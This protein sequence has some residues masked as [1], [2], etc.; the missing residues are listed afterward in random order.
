ML[1]RDESCYRWAP[2]QA[3]GDAM[4]VVLQLQVACLIKLPFLGCCKQMQ[5]Y[6]FCHDLKNLIFLG[7]KFYRGNVIKSIIRANREHGYTALIV[8]SLPIVGCSASEDDERLSSRNLIIRALC[9]GLKF[10]CVHEM[11]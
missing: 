4:L 1:V 2:Q 6:V 8:Q 10:P 9:V 11:G 7:S 3:Q 5:Q